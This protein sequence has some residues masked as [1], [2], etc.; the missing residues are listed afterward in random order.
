MDADNIIG[1]DRRGYLFD[2]D[3][4]RYVCGALDFLYVYIAIFVCWNS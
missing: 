1:E 2:V 4:M 3:V